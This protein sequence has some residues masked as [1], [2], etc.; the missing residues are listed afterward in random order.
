MSAIVS[1]IIPV[2]N[3]AAHIAS[4]I[5][6][7]R[8]Q[9]HT[10][11]EIIVIDDGSTDDTPQVVQSIAAQDSRIQ[12]LR[13]DHKGPAAARNS[14]IEKSSGD[15]IAFLDSDD[16]WLPK[17]IEIQLKAF[18]TDSVG[19]V[20]CAGWIENSAGERDEEW[21]RQWQPEGRFTPEA[22]LFHHPKFFTP[23]VVVRR[24]F[25]SKAGLFD[26][27]LRYYE[28]VDL[29][30]RLLLIS[31]GRF[32]PEELV[33][34][35]RKFRSA[36]EA[37]AQMPILEFLDCI[38]RMREKAVGLYEKSV[39]PLTPGEKR[40]AL[41]QFRVQLVKE[42]LAAGESKKARELIRD[43]DLHNPTLAFLAALPFGSSLL[44]F[45]RKIRGHRV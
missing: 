11:L 1:V 37:D 31:E 7:A 19:F 23:G 44:R 25:L 13:R 12:Y 40:I 20:Q 32:V 29:W 42:Y 39:R 6:S 38:V 10:D 3:D 35:R 30:F 4:A 14:G 18:E 27:Q 36:A 2:L 16:L 33:V 41:D 8:Q 22:I 45:W 43:W 5:D 34:I 9:S 26:E 28:D 24:F 17:K 21:T 15:F